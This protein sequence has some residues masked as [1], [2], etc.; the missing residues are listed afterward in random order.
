MSITVS[1]FAKRCFIFTEMAV[2]L[3]LQLTSLP[4]CWR[5]ITKDSSL[6]S[7]VSSS[8]MATTS[9]SFD[10]LGID[11]NPAIML[12]GANHNLKYHFV[13]GIIIAKVTSH[14][15]PLYLFI[16]LWFWTLNWAHPESVSHV[17]ASSFQLIAVNINPLHVCENAANLEGKTKQIF[18]SI[19]KCYCSVLQIGCIPTDGARGRSILDFNN[20]LQSPYQRQSVVT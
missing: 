8:N 13:Q 19:R 12:I 9:L 10:S 7:I 6:A 14:E 4:P 16:F 15:T 20:I 17:S 2:I 3:G 5:M 18:A 1:I 11:C